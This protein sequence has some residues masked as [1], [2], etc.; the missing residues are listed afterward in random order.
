MRNS[1]DPRARKSE[2]RIVGASTPNN[3]RKMP[4]RGLIK[5]LE[6][7][8]GSR[9]REWSQTMERGN[10]K[11]MVMVDDNKGAENQWERSNKTDEV[12]TAGVFRVKPLLIR[13]NF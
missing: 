4:R 7:A 13:C 3:K 9:K 5:W 2:L 6:S 10:I 11:P 12:I 1:G 8:D